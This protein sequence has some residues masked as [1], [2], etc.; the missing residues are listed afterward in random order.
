MTQKDY[1]KEQLAL[2]KIAMTG[3]IGA[4]FAM[5]VYNLQSSG[6][7]VINVMAAVIVLGIV[8]VLLGRAY[9]NLLNDLKDLP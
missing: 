4:M 7:N 2:L 6:S 8:L 5:A 9:K 3:V 1:I